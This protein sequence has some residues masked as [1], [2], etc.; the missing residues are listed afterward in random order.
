MIVETG[1]SPGLFSCLPVRNRG[2]SMFEGRDLFL[3]CIPNTGKYIGRNRS[4]K[5]EITYSNRKGEKKKKKQQ[6][7]RSILLERAIYVQRRTQNCSSFFFKINPFT[8]QVAILNDRFIKEI[9]ICL[10][11]LIFSCILKE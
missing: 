5:K 6:Q 11:V 4:E 2:D 3:K 1:F 8:L 7:P 9:P 10:F